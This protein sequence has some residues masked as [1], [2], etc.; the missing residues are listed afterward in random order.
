MLCYFLQA[1]FGSEICG[2]TH[3][4]GDHIQIWS[5]KFKTL[6]QNFNS[7]WTFNSKTFQTQ[8]SISQI[9]M[10]SSSHET[11]SNKSINPL[12]VL[13]PAVSWLAD[14]WKWNPWPVAASNLVHSSFF[15]VFS[16][17]RLPFRIVVSRSLH[18][19]VLSITAHI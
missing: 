13:P 10:F 19:G 11:S 9:M 8:S 14:A 1:F 7:L 12:P 6:D 17:A 16:P 4:I 3:E 18:I 15:N 5:N 2:M